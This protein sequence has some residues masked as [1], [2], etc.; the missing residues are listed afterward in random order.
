MSPAGRQT[1]PAVR[2][3]KQTSAEDAVDAHVYLYV[4]KSSS[5]AKA[6]TVHITYSQLIDAEVSAPTITKLLQ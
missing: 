2:M 4:G 6:G 3:D 5:T 1:P